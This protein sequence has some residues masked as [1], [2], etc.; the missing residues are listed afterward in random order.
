MPKPMAPRPRKA[1]FSGSES[2]IFEDLFLF[3]FLLICIPAESNAKRKKRR[4]GDLFLR[5]KLKLGG[6][7][8]PGKEGYCIYPVARRDLFQ[9]CGT[10]ESL[11]MALSGRFG[12]QMRSRIEWR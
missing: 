10:P 3:S 4:W 11:L 8:S 7:P 5:E 1:I 12:E 9:P 2:S 6:F